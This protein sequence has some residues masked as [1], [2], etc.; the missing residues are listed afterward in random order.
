MKAATRNRFRI[1][2]LI[3]A[4]AFL[5]LCL[6]LIFLVLFYGENVLC[7]LAFWGPTW[8]AAREIERCA[9]WLN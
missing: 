2:Y 9:N 4:P 8:I 3:F 5:V 6:I 1:A 7:A